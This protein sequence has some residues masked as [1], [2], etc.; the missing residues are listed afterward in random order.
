MTLLVHDPL[1]WRHEVDRL[2]YARAILRGEAAALEEVA[3]RLDD[4]FLQA[5]D[6]ILAAPGRVALTGTGSPPTSARKSPA[7]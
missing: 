1:V 4:S 7:P 2:T 3:D 5:V 6:L